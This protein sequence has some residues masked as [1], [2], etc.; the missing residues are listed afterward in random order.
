MISSLVPA[1]A[2][3]LGLALPFPVPATDVPTYTC[4]TVSGDPGLTV[5]FGNCRASPGAVTKGGF[6]G[7]AV[8]V[9]ETVPLR[10]RCLDGGEANL[11]REVQLRNCVQIG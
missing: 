6:V 8:G 10:I 1:A 2:F 5:M 11:P 7:E 3:L 9:A 4:D